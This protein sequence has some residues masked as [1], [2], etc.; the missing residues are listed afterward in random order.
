M[1]KKLDAA[2]EHEKT[3]YVALSATGYGHGNHG[4]M[5]APTVIGWQPSYV[6]DFGCGNNQFIRGLR[7]RGI[8]GCGV[9]F[10][11]PGADYL[12]VMHDLPLDADIADVVTSFDA[13]EHL[14][15]EDVPLVFREMQR[16]AKHGARFIMSISFR[17]SKLKSLEGEPLHMTVQPR[18]WWENQLN[19][20]G[21]IERSERSW[22]KNQL[23]RVGVIGRNERYIQGKFLKEGG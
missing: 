19:R 4:R 14:L 8:Q 23:N 13:L 21:V 20:V 5:A 2:R 7:D 10:A 17:P 22:W 15:P 6:V 9:D 11:N 18:A 1:S 12:A 3:K 16:V